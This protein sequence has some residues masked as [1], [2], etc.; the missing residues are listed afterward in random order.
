MRNERCAYN[1]KKKLGPWDAKR[2][3]IGSID[4]RAEKARAESILANQ[5]KVQ[6][7]RKSEEELSKGEAIKK[8]DYALIGK[9]DR[10]YNEWSK[11]RKLNSELKKKDLKIKE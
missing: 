7:I 5:K 9:V 2:V 8:E 3:Q 10:N 11:A 1:Q 6:N 4:S